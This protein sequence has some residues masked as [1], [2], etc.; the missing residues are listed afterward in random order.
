MGLTC[1][2]SCRTPQSS[3]EGATVH[4]VAMQ[5][6]SLHSKKCCKNSFH[7]LTSLLKFLSQVHSH[8][9]LSRPVDPIFDELAEAVFSFEN[10][11]DRLLSRTIKVPQLQSLANDI[12]SQPSL[13]STESDVFEL[14]RAAEDLDRDLADWA[15]HVPAG[16]SYSVAT[17]LNS[18]SSPE[19]ST[20]FYIPSEIHGYSDFY[21]ARVWNLYRVSRLVIQSIILRAS[22][23]NCFP[24]RGGGE[25][26]ENT[27]IENLNGV[28]VNDICSSVPFLLGYDLSQFKRTTIGINSQDDQSIW[29]QRSTSKVGNAKHTGRF[30]LIW[31]LYLSCSVSSIPE[32]QR[33]WMR[34]QLQWIAEY[35]ESQAKLVSGAQS[36]TLFGGAENFRFDCV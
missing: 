12:L 2:W 27:H 26:P 11:E 13:S 19:Q 32:T 16:W 30:S 23:S 29:P 18:M 22:S 6:V 17:N 4:A 3:R 8:V 36:R 1:G 31:P 15:R 5:Y 20:S 21:T 35:G 9:Q 28:L 14:I 7:M 33:R 10:T 34:A 24:R 25:R